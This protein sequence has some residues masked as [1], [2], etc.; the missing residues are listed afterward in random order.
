MLCKSATLPA[1]VDFFPT[2]LLGH[3]EFSLRA[4]HNWGEEARGNGVLW[5]GLIIKVVEEI[6]GY[7]LIRKEIK[8]DEKN[9]ENFKSEKIENFRFLPFFAPCLGAVVAIILGNVFVIVVEL[10]ELY[11]F[12]VTCNSDKSWRKFSPPAEG[13]VD[14]LIDSPIMESIGEEQLL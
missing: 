10:G 8:F 11:N 4:L 6:R 13:G 12:E 14:S 9:F 3:P 1:G 7:R 5:W 2:Q